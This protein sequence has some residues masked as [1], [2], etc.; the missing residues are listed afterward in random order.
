[1]ADATFRIVVDNTAEAIATKD[2]LLEVAMEAVSQAMGQFADEEVQRAIYDTSPSES[3]VRTG[4]LGRSI[5]TSYDGK[6][7]CVGTNLEYAP[8][9]EL[10]TYKMAAR[11]FIKPAVADHIEEYKQIIQRTLDGG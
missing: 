9:N 10:G 7:A 11:P 2:A 8:Y 3:Y 4:D 1:M 5:S 6:G